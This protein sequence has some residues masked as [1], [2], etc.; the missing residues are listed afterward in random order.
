MVEIVAQGLDHLLKDIV[1]IGGTAMSFYVDDPA[2][3]SPRPTEDVDCLVEISSFR[4]YY[5]L[6]RQLRTLGCE[7]PAPL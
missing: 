7:L 5:Q 1:F 6:E 3:A 4:D 2:S